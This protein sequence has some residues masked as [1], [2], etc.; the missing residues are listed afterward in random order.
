[1]YTMGIYGESHYDGRIDVIEVPNIK[2]KVIKSE[3]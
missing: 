1:M 2:R 3:K